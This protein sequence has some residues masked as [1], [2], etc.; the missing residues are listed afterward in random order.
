MLGNAGGVIIAWAIGGLPNCFQQLL[1]D[2]F[3]YRSEDMVEKGYGHTHEEADCHQSAEGDHHHHELKEQKWPS[4]RKE[5]Y[6]LEQKRGSEGIPIVTLRAAE[7]MVV[8][9]RTWSPDRR[10]PLS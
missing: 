5:A 3:A 8:M 7:K 4:L 10:E 1:A 6:R 2:G 9:P